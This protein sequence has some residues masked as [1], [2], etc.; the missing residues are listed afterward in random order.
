MKGVHDMNFEKIKW[1]CKAQKKIKDGVWYYPNLENVTIFEQ[2]QIPIYDKLVSFT[3][4]SCIK[5]VMKYK[6]Y[7]G[8]DQN[9]K[10]YL[11]SAYKKTQDTLT[12]CKNL[13]TIVT[14]LTFDQFYSFWSI[15]PYRGHCRDLFVYTEDENNKKMFVQ[16]KTKTDLHTYIGWR[17]EVRETYEKQALIEEH[18]KNTI[19]LL[20]EVQRDINDTNDKAI[21]Y[22]E[23]AIEY[24]GE[25]DNE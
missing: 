5:Q 15:N 22:Y 23:Q 3:T 24:L 7:C 14:T 13:G 20:K 19:A 17:E 4:H 8:S 2:R 6:Q 25:D 18:S 11:E 10:E 12:R 21:E 16:F 1:W 9:S